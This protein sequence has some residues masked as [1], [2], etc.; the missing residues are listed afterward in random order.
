MDTHPKR[1]AV[2][3]GAFDPVTNG[4]MDLIARG[5]KL[6][7]ELV[8][9]VGDNPAKVALFT[10]EERVEMLKELTAGMEGV[11]VESYT[12]LT[13]DF[14]RKI[15]AAAILRGIRNANDLHFEFQVALTHRAVAGVETVFVMPSSESVYTSSTLIKQIATMRGDIS[16]LVPPLVVRRLAEKVQT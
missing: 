15:G 14:V 6:F 13:V 16:A 4:H 3:P 2:L 11:R 7:D 1:V 10:H 5:V 12:G 8:V 9:A